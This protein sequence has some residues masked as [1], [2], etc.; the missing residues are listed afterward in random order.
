MLEKLENR[1]SLDLDGLLLVLR[2]RRSILLLVDD[3]LPV[4]DGNWCCD[5]DVV[6]VDGVC[7]R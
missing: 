7:I 4:A 3:D 1:R 6:L 2:I 5:G